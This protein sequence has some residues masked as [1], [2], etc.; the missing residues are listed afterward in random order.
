MKFL[1]AV[2]IVAIG[3]LTACAK[4]GSFDIGGLKY[5]GFNDSFSGLST[6]PISAVPASGTAVYVGGY[7]MN[8]QGGARAQGAASMSA[9]F[10]S[11][12]AQLTLLGGVSGGVPPG[13]VNIVGNISGGQILP[14][15]GGD[16][17]TGDFYGNN[18]EVAAGR[19]E[20]SNSS[21]GFFS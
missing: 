11:A 15:A 13:N 18:A 4:G 3:S 6:S 12:T 17:I 1:K 14:T 7:S 8:L 16:I 5:N 20:L 9:D 2:A 19:F 10:T 21:K